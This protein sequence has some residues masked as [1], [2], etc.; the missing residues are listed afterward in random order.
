MGGL[1]PKRRLGPSHY[2]G[3]LG[4]FETL[5]TGARVGLPY[6]EVEAEKSGGAPDVKKGFFF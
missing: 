4:Q 5:K 6:L 2:L 3:R 1:A